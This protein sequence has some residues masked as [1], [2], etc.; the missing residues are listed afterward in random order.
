MTI[1]FI[2][3]LILFLLISFYNWFSLIY[4]YFFYKNLKFT[5]VFIPFIGGILGGI[6]LYL[7]SGYYSLPYP[8][9]IALIM[10]PGCSLLFLMEI[11]EHIPFINR[12]KINKTPSDVI[13]LNKKMMGTCFLSIFFLLLLPVGVPIL[14]ECNGILI[15]SIVTGIM[16]TWIIWTSIL[17]RYQILFDGKQIRQKT[18]FHQKIIDVKQIK[19]MKIKILDEN[20]SKEFSLQDTERIRLNQRMNFHLSVSDGTETI[21]FKTIHFT[22]S[23]NLK[24]KAILIFFLEQKN[25]NL[26]LEGVVTI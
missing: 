22:E 18:F 25:M 3:L 6:G 26:I 2:F 14:L 16:A 5:V 17:F 7:M 19:E 24:A 23:M 9:W 13:I 1:I 8:W 21:S 4:P 12:Y 11:S 15:P 20:S 10:D